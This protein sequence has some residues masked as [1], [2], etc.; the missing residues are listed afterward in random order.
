VISGPSVSGLGS[1]LT[2][3]HVLQTAGDDT[4]AAAGTP[5][6][7][8]VVIDVDQYGLGTLRDLHTLF[9]D[10]RL[11]A[12]SDNPKTLGRAVVLGATVALPSTTPSQ[13]LVALIGRL[14]LQA[15]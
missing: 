7:S 12:V 4:F 14:A 3:V 10:I 1:G 9:P 8:V 13:Q 6:V 11:I 2:G 5:N 15:H